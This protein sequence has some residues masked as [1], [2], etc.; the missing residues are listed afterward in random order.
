MEVFAAESKP[1]DKPWTDL[2][3]SSFDDLCSV[4]GFPWLEEHI[5]QGTHWLQAKNL[6]PFDRNH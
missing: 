5:H 6:K 1:T 2:R 3:G 4:W